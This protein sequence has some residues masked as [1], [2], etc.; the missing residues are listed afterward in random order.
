MIDP[1]AIVEA[2]LRGW[3]AHDPD[4]AAESLA[5][6]VEYYDVTVGA[7]ER[8]AKAARDH[9]IAFFMGAFPDLAWTMVGDPLVAG[10]GV[11]FRWVLTGTNTGIP[12]EGDAPT[13]ARVEIDGL[14]LIRVRDGKI[15]YQGDFYDGLRLKRQL[16]LLG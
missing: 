6:D 1:R 16:G 4:L 15:V 12:V 14:S 11:A 13:G 8:G 7:P 2:Y 9:V 3:N 10:D 5:A